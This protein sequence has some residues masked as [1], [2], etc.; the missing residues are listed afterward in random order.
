MEANAQ[1]G[2]G[3]E[4]PNADCHCPD[5]YL[6]GNRGH[7]ICQYLQIRLRNGDNRPI[8]KQMRMMGKIRF[9]LLSLLPTPC[10]RGVMAISAPS[11]NSPMPTIRR[12]A[13]VRKSVRVPTSNGTRVMLSSRTI[14]VI[15]NTLERD[16]LIFSFSFSFM[17]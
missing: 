5:Q 8:T 6:A 10:P 1:H 17:P 2:Y 14:T 12:T 9:P 7:L 3:E 4:H 13:P 16:S 11:W 15:G